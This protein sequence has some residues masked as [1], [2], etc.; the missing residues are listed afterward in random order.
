MLRNAIFSP[1]TTAVATAATTTTARPKVGKL[2]NAEFS[3]AITAVATATATARPKVGM[4]R[5]AVF[6]PATTAV[7][8]STATSC[9]IGHDEPLHL[10]HL[11]TLPLNDAAHLCEL[12]QGI[13]IFVSSSAA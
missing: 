6:S 4:L 1:A 12:H 2:R 3:P 8:T 5:N 13:V 7:A 9:C 10:L 11:L